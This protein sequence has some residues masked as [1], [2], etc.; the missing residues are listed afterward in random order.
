MSA[1]SLGA[2]LPPLPRM[3]LPWRK[4]LNHWIDPDGKEWAE[5]NLPRAVR[6]V[7]RVLKEHGWPVI[8]KGGVLRFRFRDADLA[9]WGKV[10]RRTIQKGL[11]L[12]QK[13]GMLIRIRVDGER[14]I[15]LTFEFAAKDAAKDSPKSARKKS[16][17]AAPPPSPPPGEPGPPLSPG[18]AAAIVRAA[19][20]ELEADPAPRF[21]V[22]PSLAAAL[23]A[24]PPDDQEKR[25]RAEEKRERMRR[26]EAELAA[27]RAAVE[28]AKAKAGPA[29][30]EET[31]RE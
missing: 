20:A 19:E 13:L 8:Q 21:T 7:L 11:L 29:P 2:T 16:G 22:D 28:A 1:S 15:E 30:P 14:V 25:R 27:H 17:P 3:R 4:T 9:R 23:P 6:R 18:E 26:T 10:V 5:E 24:P 31:P 12:A